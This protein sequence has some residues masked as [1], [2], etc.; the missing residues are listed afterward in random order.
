MDTEYLNAWYSQYTYAAKLAFGHMG[1][2]T[3]EVSDIYRQAHIILL[4]ICLMAETMSPR[5]REDAFFELQKLY[6]SC[7]PSIKSMH[8]ELQ[9]RAP[10]T[11]AVDLFKLGELDPFNRRLFELCPKSSSYFESAFKEIQANYLQAK[12]SG[13]EYYVGLAHLATAILVGGLAAAS[14]TMR[15]PLLILAGTLVIFMSGLVLGIALSRSAKQKF[16]DRLSLEAILPPAPVPVLEAKTLSHPAH[17]SLIATPQLEA[18]EDFRVPI[19]P[20]PGFKVHIEQTGYGLRRNITRARLERDYTAASAIESLPIKKIISAEA[21]ASFGLQI[22]HE[23][24]VFTAKET[25]SEGVNP[26]FLCERGQIPTYFTVR[27]NVTEIPT[28]FLDDLKTGNFDSQEE[29]KVLS[30]KFGSN[31][32][33]YA[34]KIETGVA[35]RA[36]YMVTFYES[37]AHLG[38]GKVSPKTLEQAYRKAP[39]ASE[40]KLLNAAQIQPYL[41]EACTS[42]ASR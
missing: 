12:K 37:H 29:A 17:S 23:N 2:E 6:R 26:I 4:R 28:E 38:S 14:P 10:E 15:H 3:C 39:I 35:G 34:V 1:L 42:A 5:L 13:L 21:P 18:P 7:S 30:L 22:N 8:D 40:I 20:A 25:L 32:R 27:Q 33:L 11:V 19:F 9:T 41:E 36:L 31:D 24:Y 16:L